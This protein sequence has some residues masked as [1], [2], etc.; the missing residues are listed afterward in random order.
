[1]EPGKCP[2]K[3]YWVSSSGSLERTQF[4]NLKPGDRVRIVVAQPEFSPRQNGMWE[5]EVTDQPAFSVRDGVWRIV[6]DDGTHAPVSKKLFA[7]AD[8]RHQFG[9]SKS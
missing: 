8:A 4:S 7:E 2:P 3:T 9:G 6:C 5:F 1:M